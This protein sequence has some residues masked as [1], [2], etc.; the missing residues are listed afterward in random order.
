M[1]CFYTVSLLRPQTWVLVPKDL[2]KCTE[3]AL[4]G[5]INT[6]YMLQRENLSS[7]SRQ[8]QTLNA[9]LKHSGVA[10]GGAVGADCPPLGFWSQK[11]GGSNIS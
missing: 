4:K 7:P 3:M 10:S 9:S 2:L 5:N 8:N 6:K 11:S 1:F